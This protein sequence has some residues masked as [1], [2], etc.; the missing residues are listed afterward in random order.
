MWGWGQSSSDLIQNVYQAATRSRTMS[1]AELQ[2]RK[3]AEA[4]I[5]KE[6]KGTCKFCGEEIFK[7]EAMVWESESLLSFCDQSTAKNL[8][9][10]I[11]KWSKEDGVYT[12]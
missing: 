7:N 4:K 9:Q 1:N 3:E 11:V 10:P 6:G 5:N 8:H 2:S 12:P